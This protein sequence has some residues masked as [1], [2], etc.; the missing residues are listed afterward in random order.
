MGSRDSL[1]SPTACVA[2]LFRQSNAMVD[3]PPPQ[4]P[5]L[6]LLLLRWLHVHRPS[7]RTKSAGFGDVAAVNRH[8]WRALVDA[9]G[10]A[11]RTA[12]GRFELGHL[13]MCAGQQ[14]AIE[15]AR[16]RVEAL[17]E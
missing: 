12:R 13:G 15:A 11:R 6:L 17:L 7:R 2:R 8:P 5:P 16:V 14:L 4:A 10:T 9:Q 1:R 3:A